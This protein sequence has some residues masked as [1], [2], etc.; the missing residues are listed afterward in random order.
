MTD[1]WK[2]LEGSRGKI[3]VDI[4]DWVERPPPRQPALA[5]VSRLVLL[6]WTEVEE[7]RHQPL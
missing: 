1:G 3:A 6:R 5:R 2:E 4:V 7:E